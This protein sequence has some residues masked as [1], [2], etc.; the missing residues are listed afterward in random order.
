MFNS[1]LTESDP[2]GWS[3][4]VLLCIIFISA[5]KLRQQ[6]ESKF[7]AFKAAIKDESGRLESFT[8]IPSP[9]QWPIIGHM[10]L[11]KDYQDN[12]WIGFNK[13]RDEYGNIVRLKMGLLSMVMVSGYALIEEVLDQKGQFFCDRPDFKRL[14]I[15]FG[16]RAHSLALCDF[17]SVHK[18]RRK[19]CKKGIVPSTISPRNKLLESLIIKHVKLFTDMVKERSSPQSTGEHNLN[20]SDKHSLVDKS[21]ILFLT[22]DVFLEFLAGEKRSH[23]NESYIK[24][25]YQADFIFWDIQQSYIVDFFPFL[26]RLGV[27]RKELKHLDRISSDLRNYVDEDVFYP[28]LNRLENLTNRAQ[29]E[30]IFA[31]D[32]SVDFLDLMIMTYLNKSNAMT[33]EDY[34]V[35]FADL[36]VGHAAVANILMRVLG[37]LSLNLDVQEKIYEEAIRVDIE[38]LDHIPKLPIT[39]STLQESLR[40]AS[41]PIVPHLAKYDSSIGDYFIPKGTTILFNNYDLNLSKELWQEP[42]KWDPMR[43]INQD[44]GELKIPNHFKPFSIGKRRCLGYKMVITICVMAVSHICKKFIINTDSPELTEEL[45]RPRGLLALN[46]DAK[47]FNLKLYPR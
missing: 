40:I 32:D 15:V 31:E 9:P 25:T 5:M 10:H 3:T 13:I 34:R 28:R 41:S 21:D 47:C 20:I 11:M 42:L 1:I 6:R 18:Y 37:H 7:K 19:L 30:E 22:S 38:N 46:P 17:S 39:E 33:L 43:F 45:L 23:T 4:P 16:A 2:I 27:C 24:F 14:E 12:H 26:S 29:T 44:T 35:G 8:S 36:Y